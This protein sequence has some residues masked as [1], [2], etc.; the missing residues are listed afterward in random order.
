MTI[1]CETCGDIENCICTVSYKE[2]LEMQK[3]IHDLREALK[4]Y[5]DRDS[6]TI[7]SKYN[8]LVGVDKRRAMKLLGIPIPNEMEEDD[9][10]L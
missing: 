2:F 5:V 6:S 3:Q 4:W 1:K 8:K 9:D 7:Y 10:T